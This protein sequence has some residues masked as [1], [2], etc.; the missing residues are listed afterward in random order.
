MVQKIY[1]ILNVLNIYKLKTIENHFV[2]FKYFKKPYKNI[3]AFYLL[4][5][6]V[7]SLHGLKKNICVERNKIFQK[8]KQIKSKLG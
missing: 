2:D 1:Y 4:I 6:F 3:K 5:F 7:K 8:F